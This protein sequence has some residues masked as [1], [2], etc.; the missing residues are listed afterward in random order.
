MQQQSFTLT[1]CPEMPA[2]AI[3]ERCFQ[4]STA[5]DATASYPSPHTHDPRQMLK[6]TLVAYCPSSP[7]VL[8]EAHAPLPRHASLQ[9]RSSMADLL[10]RV[11]KSLLRSS[12]VGVQ[13]RYSL[14]L[15]VLFCVDA[16]RSPQAVIIETDSRCR[17]CHFSRHPLGVRAEAV[18]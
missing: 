9:H 5:E 10:D 7:T 12:S 16:L 13:V 1:L 18:Y 3:S 15:P 2:G 17:H 8:D 11:V 6:E 14:F 4:H